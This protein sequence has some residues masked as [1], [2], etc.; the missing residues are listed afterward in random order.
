[1]TLPLPRVDLKRARNRNRNRNRILFT[2]PFECVL[3][4]LLYTCISTFHKSTPTSLHISGY[5]FQAIISLQSSPLSSCRRV[6]RLFFSLIYPPPCLNTTSRCLL[7]TQ[8]CLTIHHARVSCTYL[9]TVYHCSSVLRR[10]RPLISF[11]PVS[12]SFGAMLATTATL[13]TLWHFWHY[14]RFR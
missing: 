4:P 8:Y 2:R 9:T 5:R 11:S 6:Y 1:M 14:D 3:E 12:M 7:L 10:G 13:F